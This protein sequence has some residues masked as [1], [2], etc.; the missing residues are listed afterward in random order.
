MITLCMPI[1]FAR[2]IEALGIAGGT[3]GISGI[4]PLGN[5]YL[6]MYVPAI[7]LIILLFLLRRFMATDYG[8]I[9]RGIR[10]N[11]LSIMAS[12]INVYHYKFMAIFISSVM[13]C[14]TGAYMAHYYQFVGVSAFSLDYS[15]IPLTCAILGGTDSFA[16]SMLGAFIIM[17]LSESL[18]AFGTLRIVIYSLILAGLLLLLPEGIFHYIQ[19]KYHQLERWKRI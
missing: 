18:R 8:L 14:F 10:D 11:E 9:I 17:P 16:G 13:G 4:N 1:F 7:L 6:E 12:G 15:M 2:I 19:R 5:Y 3:S